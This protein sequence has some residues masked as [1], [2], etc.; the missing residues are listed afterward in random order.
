M[1][2][3][4]V[5]EQLTRKRVLLLR[6]DVTEQAV[7]EVRVRMVTLALES[8]EE[9]ILAID[10][11]GGV[12]VPSL[13]LVDTMRLISAPV[14]GIVNGRCFSAGVMILQGCTTRVATRHSSFYLHHVHGTFPYSLRQNDAQIKARLAEDLREAREQDKQVRD[15]LSKRSGQSRQTVTVL[16]NE[17]EKI[18]RFYTA[19]E[20]K[21]LGFVDKV[22]DSCELF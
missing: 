6:G 22:I 14:K 13:W 9:I 3:E 10:T 8:T 11:K 21:K 18:N 1:N 16:I 17:G 7:E 20:A 19:L 2:T 4:S 12:N 15:L 5:K